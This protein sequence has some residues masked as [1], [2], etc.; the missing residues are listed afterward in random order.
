MQC[1]LPTFIYKLCEQTTVR[2][3]SQPIKGPGAANADW[4][5]YRSNPLDPILRE[6]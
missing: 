4:L 3:S 6:S 5:A 2:N 1:I